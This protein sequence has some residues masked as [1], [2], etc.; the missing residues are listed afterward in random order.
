MHAIFVDKSFA[1]YNDDC[2][3]LLQNDAFEYQLVDRIRL[4][5]QSYEYCHAIIKNHRSPFSSSESEM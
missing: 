2:F 5:I 1:N 3:R 4:T